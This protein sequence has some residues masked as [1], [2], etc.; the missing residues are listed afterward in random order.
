M[1]SRWTTGRR[2]S[3]LIYSNRPRS[4]KFQRAFGPKGS[5]Y[6][7]PGVGP[8]TS[9]RAAKG[10]NKGRGKL[11][12]RKEYQTPGPTQQCMLMKRSVIPN[13]VLIKLPYCSYTLLNS[14][15]VPGYI[16]YLWGINNAYDPDYS[17]VG[18]QPRGFDQWSG[19]YAGWMVH[20]CNYDIQFLPQSSSAIADVANTM[21]VGIQM[22]PEGYQTRFSDALDCLE[23]GQSKYAQSMIVQRSSQMINSAASGLGAFQAQIGSRKRAGAGRFTGSVRMKN[24]VSYYSAENITTGQIYD[25]PRDYQATIGQ[26]CAAKLNLMTWVAGLPQNGGTATTALPFVYVLIKLEMEVEF[27]NPLTPSISLHEGS[28]G[29]YGLRL[30]PGGTGLQGPTGP[31]GQ[32]LLGVPG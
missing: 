5:L 8:M 28:T 21:V 22:F 18:H 19:L 9:R 7:R 13:R 24:L 11:V 20:K 17:G 3:S 4:G 16:E 2:G 31:M 14:T 10:K 1:Q 29:T 12:S 26:Q 30:P 25:W 32:G 27:F 23:Q 15:E 6:R